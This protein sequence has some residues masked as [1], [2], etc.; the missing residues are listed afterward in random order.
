MDINMEIISKQLSHYNPELF[1]PYGKNVLLKGIKILEKNQTHFDPDLLYLGKLSCF[2][3]KLPDKTRINMVCIADRYV[4]KKYKNNP[5][6]NLLIL[7][8]Q[9]NFFAVFNELQDLFTKQQKRSYISKKLMDSL[10]KGNGL[11][12]IADVGLE[13]MGNPVIILNI[14]NNTMA[15][16]NVKL[17][18]PLWNE[19][20]ENK[21]L[22]YE[23]ALKLK[24]T[25]VKEDVFKSKTPVFLEEDRN[26]TNRLVANV[27]IEEKIA[28]HIVVLDLIRKFDESDLDIV[29]LLADAVSLEMQ[30]IRAMQY[31]KGQMYEYFINDLL[32]GKIFSE[33]EMIEKIKN[34]DLNLEEFN[35]ILTIDLSRYNDSNDT[36]RAAINQISQIIKGS[37]PI[38]FKDKIVTLISRSAKNLL[39]PSDE[40]EIEECLTTYHLVGGL[41]L[42]FQNIL[43]LQKYYLQSLKAIELGVYMKADRHLYI[44]REYVLIHLA[45]V[46]AQQNDLKTFCHP[47]VFALQEFDK[48]NH[49]NYLK[50]LDIYIKNNRNA[51]ASSNALHIHRNT[52]DYRISKISEMVDIDWNNGDL[53]MHIYLSL[54]MLDYMEA[55]GESK[56]KLDT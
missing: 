4:S 28:A 8:R 46:C 30:K 19:L 48:K 5:H 34:S 18:D 21:Y 6:F 40:K 53:L 24:A 50:S 1:M 54:K 26:K 29:G 33:K 42:S 36:F 51:L 23:L 38:V 25:G 15:C 27:F 11:Q 47:S 43:D 31:N 10:L 16:S 52:L 12:N 2:P 32:E 39:N 45:Q 35:Y 13:I 9:V 17:S 41:S 14:T 3:E 7:D 37:T 56:Q 22:S 55:S 44:Y 20:V 49:T